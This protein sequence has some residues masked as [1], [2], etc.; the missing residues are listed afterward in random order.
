MAMIP[1]M[2]AGY[3][4]DRLMGGSGMTGL[5][6]G[7]GVGGFSTGAFGGL[8]EGALAPE[9]TATELGTG[10]SGFAQYPALKAPSI[11]SSNITGAA[12]FTG[13]NMMTSFSQGALSP[14][15]MTNPAILA[16]AEQLYAAPS[17][18]EQGKR[19]LG[20]GLDTV[21]DFADNPVT[22]YINTGWE[23]M[24]FGD[25]SSA[26]MMG[27][28]AVDNLTMQ[29]QNMIQPPQQREVIGKEPNIAAPLAINVP[30][31]GV[32]IRTTG[33]LERMLTP[34]QRRAL[35]LL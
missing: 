35:G 3:A 1:Y 30:A 33:Q 27:N 13:A 23:D 17:L 26:L 25:K 32:N 2:A 21:S 14:S 15:M 16:N 8:F 6:I 34:E 4:A 18:F 5:A 24:D 10:A 7:S 9:L 11:L 29:P 19:A 20:A 28:Q 31:S 22:R 12:P